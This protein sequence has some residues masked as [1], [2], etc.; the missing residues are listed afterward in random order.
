MQRPRIHVIHFLWALLLGIGCT[1]A[2]LLILG[3][4]CGPFRRPRRRGRA[5]PD[6]F[7]PNGEIRITRDH[8]ESPEPSPPN[9]SP[10]TIPTCP[11][12]ATQAS[13]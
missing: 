5:A 12:G 13:E 8:Q 3:F 4:G 2:L 1:F 6:P 11:G 9:T 10:S 7:T